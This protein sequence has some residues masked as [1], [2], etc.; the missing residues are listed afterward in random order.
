MWHWQCF[1]LAWPFLRL[2][3]RSERFWHAGKASWHHAA[4]APLPASGQNGIYRKNDTQLRR[5]KFT[6]YMIFILHSVFT[7]EK[8][9][10]YVGWW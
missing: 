7:P 4:A 6:A 2:L 9:K 10:T 5:E 8:R 1:V 3:G